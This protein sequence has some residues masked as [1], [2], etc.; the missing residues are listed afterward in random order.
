MRGQRMN[1]SFNSASMPTP[2]PRIM[3]RGAIRPFAFGLALPATGPGYGEA[4]LPCR[5]APEIGG[6]A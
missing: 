1:T 6:G 4:G 3:E 5:D 2:H